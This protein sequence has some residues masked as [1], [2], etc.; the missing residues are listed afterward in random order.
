MVNRSLL[1]R[2]LTWFSPEFKQSEAVFIGDR[3]DSDIA[4]ANSN[5]IPSILVETGVNTRKDVKDIQPSAVI[6]NLSVFQ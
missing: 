5:G 1:L 4:F 6:S 3:I 2:I